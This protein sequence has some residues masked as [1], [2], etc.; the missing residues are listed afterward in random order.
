MKFIESGVAFKPKNMKTFIEGIFTVQLSDLTSSSECSDSSPPVILARRADL[1]DKH[2]PRKRTLSNKYQNHDPNSLN[3]LILKAILQKTNRVYVVILLSMLMQIPLASYCQIIKD[4][5]KT[6]TI[7][8]I[9]TDSKGTT[10]PG[11]TVKIDGTIRGTAA[12]ENGVFQIKE[13]PVNAKL[14]FSSISY[15]SVTVPVDGKEKINVTLEA[16]LQSLDEVVITSFATQKKASVIGAIETIKVNDLKVPSSSLINTLGGRA[17]GIITL[18]TRGTPGQESPTFYIRG[19]NTFGANQ[20][21]L[22]LVDGIERSIDDIDPEEIESISILKDA[23]ATALY[24]VRGANGVLMITSKKGVEGKM[25]INAKVEY[26]LSGLTRLPQFVDAATWATMYNEATLN[27]GQS[28]IYTASDIAKYA[29]GSDPY[30]HPN[31]DWEKEIFKKYANNERGNINIS[32]GGGIAKYFISGSYLRETGLFKTDPTYQY[33]TNIDFSRYNFRSNL[34]LNLTKNT[35]LEFHLYNIASDGNLPSSSTADILGAV[36]STVPLSL[37]VMYPGGIIAGSSSANQLNPYDKVT[38]QG[39]QTY[40]SNAINSDITITQNLKSLTPGLSIRG[41]FAYDANNY[42]AILRSRYVSSYQATGLDASGNLILNQVRV[43]S[44]SLGYTHSTTGTAQQYL[45]FAALYDR[46]F[47]KNAVTGLLLYNQSDFKNGQATT[48]IDAIDKRNQGIA[49]RVAY[50]YDERYF[51]EFNFGYN[52]SENFAPDHRYGFFPSIAAGWIVT[53]EPW[54]KNSDVFNLIKLKGSY[55]LAGND[56]IGGRRFGYTTTVGTGLGGYN[57]GPNGEVAFTGRGEAESGTTDLTWERAAKSNVGLELRLFKN[58]TVETDVF[59]EKRTD[60]LLRRA[61][62]PNFVGITL[63]PYANLG[64]MEN[65]G[66][67]VS[68]DYTKKFRKFDLRLFG[69]FGFNR[70]KVLSKDEPLNTPAYQ[71]AAGHPLSQNQGLVAIGLFKDAS[72]VAN[73]PVQTYGTYG[74][75]DIKYLDYNSDG[76]IDDNDRVFVGKTTL[77]EINYGAG[78][79]INYSNFSLFAFFQ[80]VGSVSIIPD[81]TSVNQAFGYYPFVFTGIRGQILSDYKGN[82]W[83][84]TN[85]DAKYPRLSL[86]NANNYRISTFW[87]QNVSYIRFKSLQASYTIKGRLLSKAGISSAK[88]YTDMMNIITW[89]TF[90]LWDP[91]LGSNGSDYPP[92][93]TFNFGFALSF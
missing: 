6:I 78:I 77:P 68:A 1:Q 34:D 59:Y 84:P 81:P 4:D 83:T 88:I 20:T 37:P 91:Q 76:K 44:P 11:A 64:S 63:S 21:P 50:S 14:V 53:N 85:T 27:S 36:Y 47:G 7:S 26:G 69:N 40:F 28:P 57:F 9:I 43:G 29:D 80:G 61:G 30:L 86:Q 2:V 71:T 75:G 89:S 58:L 24:G 46:T 92:E 66:I 23:T 25:K 33:N 60:I 93:K 82:Y 49:G 70:N 48:Y 18:Q 45:E 38:Q 74:P 15:K 87:M 54:L 19:L 55:G 16:D 3:H 13:V 62:V 8:G 22:T 73:S 5:T 90:K 72:D 67:D 31:V 17:A 65:K 35:F 42:S 79:G 56:Q 10:L 12:N 39:Y 41:R 52:G 32:G 51:T